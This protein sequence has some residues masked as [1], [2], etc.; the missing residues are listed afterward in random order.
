MSIKEKV[1]FVIS[2]APLT[3]LML[4]WGIPR[5]K[6]WYIRNIKGVTPIDIV[7]ER[8]ENGDLIPFYSD[9]WLCRGNIVAKCPVCKSTI[10]SDQHSKCYKCGSYI[11]WF[12]ITDIKTDDD[13]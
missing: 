12:D 2:I 7:N 5:F 9:L 6:K 1:L 10:V 11:R 3:G 8:D 4:Y 13:L